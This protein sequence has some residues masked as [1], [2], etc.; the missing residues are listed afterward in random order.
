[1]TSEPS[2]EG[3]EPSFSER[4]LDFRTM[5]VGLRI[6][7]GIVIAQIAATFLLLLLQHEPST[8]PL[9]LDFREEPLIREMATISITHYFFSCA[10]LLIGMA[11]FTRGIMEAHRRGA[12]A[13]LSILGMVY[14]LAILAIRPSLGAG[15]TLLVNV[16]ILGLLGGVFWFLVMLAGGGAQLTGTPFRALI[17]RDGWTRKRFNWMGPFIVFLLS[18]AFFGFIIVGNPTYFGELLV[19]LRTPFVILFLIAAVDWAEL[20]DFFTRSVAKRCHLHERDTYLLPAATI[21]SASAIC[22][23]AYNIYRL[24][25]NGFLVS[26]LLSFAIMAS[27]L[28][29]L[30]VAGF[31][32]N[33]PIQF[34][35]VALVLVIGGHRMLV[36][37]LTRYEVA[38][39]LAIAIFFTV[40]ASLLLCLCGRITRFTF[41]AP[42]FLFALLFGV[43]LILMNLPVN[44]PGLIY[45]A[46]MSGAI[47]IFNV[48]LAT[49][50]ILGWLAIKRAGIG[51][52]RYPLRLLLVLNIC[53]FVVDQLAVFYMAVVTSELRVVEAVVV[54]AAVLGEILFSGHAITNVT[55]EWFPR[56]SRVF[57]FFSFVTITLATV[58]FWAPMHGPDENLKVAKM[59]M[60]PEFAV[61]GGLLGIAPALLWTLFILRLGQWFATKR[62][63]RQ[64][65]P[66]LGRERPAA[67]S[68]A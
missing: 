37:V 46:S 47:A 11:L 22:L 49:L 39:P 45:L 24:G 58:L 23:T 41:L 52:L 18:F 48:A 30:R 10:F 25:S 12:M 31:R 51:D 4:L 53:L 32:G 54:A 13:L 7:T 16:Y 29:L 67:Q 50:W 20:V 33:W 66:E 62:T 5:D 59:L 61:L 44:L 17:Y 55:S 57:L 38:G 27:I 21:L 42:T 40:V 26:L 1:M 14:I 36:V 60:N 65:A 43:S 28:L 64:A 19:L 15:I 8:S 3:S 63:V 68:L 9:A 6:L 35:W 2:H 34:P 56:Q